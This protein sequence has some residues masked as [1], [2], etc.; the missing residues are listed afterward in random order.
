MGARLEKTSEQPVAALLRKLIRRHGSAAAAAEKWGVSARTLAAY[1]A[2]ESSPKLKFIDAVSKAEG[3][4]A[5]ALIAGYAENRKANTVQ[6]PLRDVY[7]SA[8]PGAENDDERPSRFLAFDPFFVEAWGIPPERVEAI[9]ARGD[10]M[11]PTIMNQ[12]VVL[13]DRGDR[14]LRERRVFA[15]RTADGLRLKRFQR[16]VDGAVLLVSDNQAL[17]APERIAVADLDALRVAGRAF[18]TGRDV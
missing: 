8:G 9:I 11:E 6:I 17:Y 3:V 16:A 13:L 14:Q 2:G 5:E 1:L 4:D 7:A 10:S 15:F 18:W 12:S